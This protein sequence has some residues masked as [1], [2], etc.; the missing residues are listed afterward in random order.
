MPWSVTWEVTRGDR[1]ARHGDGANRVYQREHV[2]FTLHL[3]DVNQQARDFVLDPRN[4]TVP[5]KMQVTGLDDEGDSI[6]TVPVESARESPLDFDYH[7]EW[8]GRKRITFR[9]ELDLHRAQGE[10]HG[11]MGARAATRAP[12]PRESERYDADVYETFPRLSLTI[13]FEVTEEATEG[14]AA[15]TAVPEGPTARARERRIESERAEARAE[16]RAERAAEEADRDDREARVVAERDTTRDGLLQLPSPWS[17]LL[18]DEEV[19]QLGEDAMGEYARDLQA[20]IRRTPAISLNGTQYFDGE[21][22]YRGYWTWAHDDGGV[23]FYFHAA[24]VSMTTGGFRACDDDEA[25]RARRHS[26]RNRH[27]EYDEMIVGILPGERRR[28]LMS[29]RAFASESSWTRLMAFIDAVDYVMTAFDVVAIATGAGSVIAGVRRAAFWLVRGAGRLGRHA[30]SAAVRHSDDLGRAARAVLPYGDDAARTSLELARG[31]GGTTTR[32]GD[33]LARGLAR[34]GSES[35]D[36]ARGLARSAE[37]SADEARGLA[38]ESSPADDTARAADDAGV[39]SAF[40]DMV[41]GARGG[42]GA[43]TAAA[44]EPYVATD[45]VRRTFDRARAAFSRLQRGYARRLGLRARSGAQVHHAIELN[46]IQRY[47]DDIFSVDELNSIRNMRGIVPERTSAGVMHTRYGLRQL[48]NSAIRRRWD[49]F[50]ERINRVIADERLVAGTPAYRTRVRALLEEGRDRIDDEFGALFS[51]SG[52][53]LPD[54]F[55][56][57]ATDA[58]LRGGRSAEDFVPGMLPRDLE[59]LGRAVPGGVDLDPPPALR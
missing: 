13:P 53:R 30:L 47:G 38:P 55:V 50:Y 27:F 3:R 7:F 29:A 18:T 36:E 37:G 42:R 12:V 48:H 21:H 31:V 6:R 59:S 2:R 51:G 8:P 44:P 32:S 20:A 58:G 45:A 56:D 40:D 4:W 52:A 46:V 10:L 9:G 41:S 11:D 16:R 5:P 34:E 57:A 49:Q 1:G 35:A 22:H 19:G 17:R 26:S 23:M 15:A 43:A 33:D 25:G 14:E 54:T 39:D 24:Q 28:T